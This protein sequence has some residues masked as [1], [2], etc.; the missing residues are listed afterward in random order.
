MPARHRTESA[1]ARSPGF[2]LVRVLRLTGV[3]VAAFLCAPATAL[4][5]AEAITLALERNPS[6]A[7][8]QGKLAEAEADLRTARAALLP[9]FSLSASY[10]RLND[11]RL[12]PAGAMLTGPGLFARETFAGALGRHTLFDGGRTGAGI[13]G[14]SLGIEAQQAALGVAREETAYQVSQ[15]YYRVLE[16]RA[17]VEVANAGLARQREFEQ[18]TGVLFRAGRATRLD[19]MKAEAQRVDAERTAQRA[20]EVAQLA[21][22]LLRRALGTGMDER[23]DPTD[24]LPEGPH[25]P[26][27]AAALS[28]LA[29]AANA[30]L[31]RLDRQLE[32]AREQVAAA[33]AGRAP[34][35]SLQ[36]SYGYRDRDVGGSA[37]E[38]TLGVFASWTLFDGGA[39]AGQIAKAQA[40]VAQLEDTRRAAEIAVQADV[41]EALSAWRSAQ[42]DEQAAA[43]LRAANA[44]ALKA[45]LTLYRSGKATGLDVLTAQTDLTRA[46]GARAQALTAYAIARARLVRL[47]GVSDGLQLEEAR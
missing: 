8:E 35:V 26:K 12:S 45:A 46:E 44:E 28:A 29:L 4:T 2:G 16:A 13:R 34:E 47:T 15:A 41:Q 25:T 5:L 18:L 20:E 9:R 1:V 39:T 36:G 43:R 6:L 33:R 38:W 14:A 3:M 40:R 31:A 32:Q 42:A 17:L 21:L 10:N 19:G 37:Q 23:L 7:V 30:E 24:R 22:V 11:D 27:G